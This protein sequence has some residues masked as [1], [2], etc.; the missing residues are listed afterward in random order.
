MPPLA[1][2]VKAD[3][4]SRRRWGPTQRI[5]NEFWVKWRKK[6][7][8]SLQNRQ[9]WNNKCRFFQKDCIVL[10]KTEGN[11]NQWPMTK[12]VGVNADD[13]VFVQSVPLLLARSP[14]K[15]V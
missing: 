1:Q 2:L 10:F 13:M 3:E 15:A 7:L 6:F 14:K 4:F 8:W 5:A 12:L 11:R 9:K